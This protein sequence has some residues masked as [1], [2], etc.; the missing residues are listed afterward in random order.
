MLRYAVH[1]DFV[2]SRVDNDVH[3]ITGTRLMTLYGVNP[4]ECIVIDPNESTARRAEL[5]KLAETEN[6]IHLFPR[7]DG[8]YRLPTK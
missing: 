5:F 6:L 8:N 2:L 1:P 7:Y 3:Y 4:A